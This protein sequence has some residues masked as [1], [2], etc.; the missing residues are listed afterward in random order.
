MRASLSSAAS[1][2]LAVQSGMYIMVIRHANINSKMEILTGV[3]AEQRR[4]GH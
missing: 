2:P 1:V 4:A 3:I